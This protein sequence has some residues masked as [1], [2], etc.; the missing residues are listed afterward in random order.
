MRYWV[1]VDIPTKSFLH[2]EGCPFEVNKKETLLKGIAKLKKDGGWLSFPSISEA[3]NYFEQKHP[4]K[5]L[6]IHSCID[7]HSE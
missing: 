3:K 6:F 1:N 5:T 7:L 2:V 4:N